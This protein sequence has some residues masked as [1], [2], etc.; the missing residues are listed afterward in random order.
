[1]AT[2][3]I[4]NSLYVYG[5]RT[6]TAPVPATLDGEIQAAGL[7]EPSG[8]VVDGAGPA[9]TTIGFNDALSVAD[10]LTLGALMEANYTITSPLAARATP[11]P[12]KVVAR[13]QK[14]PGTTGTLV[15][16]SGTTDL[17]T[18][19]GTPSALATAAGQGVAYASNA[20]LDAGA[21][22]SG[23]P[24]FEQ[25]QRQWAPVMFARFVTGSDL[26]DQVIWAGL[27]SGDPTNEVDP[28]GL[29]IVAIRYDDATSPNWYLVT[30]DGVTIT[31]IDTGIPVV[32][33]TLYE[34]E[35][36]TTEDPVLTAS[37][38]INTVAFVLADHDCTPPT[39]NQDLGLVVQLTTTAAASK[40]LAVAVAQVETF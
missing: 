28:A 13:W 34:V 37:F 2:G 29:H 14:A 23:P 5:Y 19:V 1:M 27:V 22:W 16:A 33:D 21:G 36:A 30:K 38:H 12:T 6:D 10:E 11:L 26:T 3:P 15:V 25:T 24:G 31:E 18:E 8:L 7:P 40:D 32:A 20:A 4:G 9:E 39:A 35:V 17:I